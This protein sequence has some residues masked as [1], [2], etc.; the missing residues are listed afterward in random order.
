MVSVTTLIIAILIT[1]VVTATATV[2]IYRNN[3]RTIGKVADKVDGIYDI[4]KEKE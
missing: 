1:A 4:V 3:V 2:F